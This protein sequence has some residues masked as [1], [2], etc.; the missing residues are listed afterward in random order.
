MMPIMTMTTSSSTT[1][2]RMNRQSTGWPDIEDDPEALGRSYF[3]LLEGIEIES[4]QVWNPHREKDALKERSYT[5]A[6]K[7][8]NI[9]AKVD[10]NDNSNVK[11]E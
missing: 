2:Y 6:I 4:R 9:V 3:G 7:Q 8:I 11:A 10:A 1:T 5:E